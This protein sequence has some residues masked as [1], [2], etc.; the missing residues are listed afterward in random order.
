MIRGHQFNKEMFIYR[1]FRRSVREV[2]PTVMG[3][4][5]ASRQPSAA[6]DSAGMRKTYDIVWIPSMQIYRKSVP[7][8]L[9]ALSAK[10]YYRKAD[11]GRLTLSH[12]EWFGARDSYHS[13]LVEHVSNPGR[14]RSEVLDRGCTA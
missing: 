6:G 10:E 1:R 4:T 12:I 11:T 2:Q 14:R 13:A 7:F 5:C 9:R 8:R 3:W